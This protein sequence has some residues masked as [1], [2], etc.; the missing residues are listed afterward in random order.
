[1]KYMKRD[2]VYKAANVTFNPKTKEAYS[3][4]WWRFVQPYKGG[5]IFNSYGYSPTTIKHQYKLRRLLQQLD[6]PIVLD[7]KAPGGL[8]D[9]GSAID[10][11]ESQIKNLQALI[12][13]PGTRKAKNEERK[14]EIAVLLFKLDEV[15]KLIKE[16]KV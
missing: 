5:V 4:D 9:L 8:Q 14:Q 2:K 6:I 13:K 10:L 3:Y 15:N 1:M 16:S 11:Y 7:V 12:A